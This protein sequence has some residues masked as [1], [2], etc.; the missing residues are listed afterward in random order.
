MKKYA[1]FDID[2]TIFRSS[3]VIEACERLVDVGIFPESAR[4]HYASQKQ[5]WHERESADSYDNYINA[6]VE[7]FGLYIKGVSIDEFSNVCDYVITTQ[8]KKTY[9]YT[10]NLVKQLKTD[11]YKLFAISGS[12]EQLVKRFCDYY[13]FTG[14]IATE[15]LSNEG[16][17]T[18]ECLPANSNKFASLQKLCDANNLNLKSPLSIGVGD[19][20]S[21]ASMLLNTGRAIAFNPDNQLFTKAR[22]SN[23]D[24][25]VERKNVIYQMTPKGTG[26]ELSSATN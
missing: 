19:T 21:D 22:A 25:V 24:I 17:Y 8:A 3:L 1:V 13:D 23:W 5:A 7:S 4:S 6:V 14:Y 18:G 11:G 15:Y 12:P 20:I 10:R 2:G 9:V 16:V 26:Y